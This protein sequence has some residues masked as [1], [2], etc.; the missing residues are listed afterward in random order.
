[1]NKEQL[2]CLVHKYTYCKINLDS[3]DSE[4]ARS[5]DVH[6][7]AHCGEV[8]IDG[9]NVYTNLKPSLMSDADGG[10]KFFKLHRVGLIELYMPV[11]RIQY[12]ERGKLVLFLCCAPLYCEC[13]RRLP[14]SPFVLRKSG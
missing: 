1:M 14:L 3:V 9:N 8:T 7:L 5:G 4:V 2:L 6:M 10:L 12:A 11:F 13:D